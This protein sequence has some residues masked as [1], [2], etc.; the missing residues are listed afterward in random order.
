MGQALPFVGAGLGFLVGGPAGAQWGWAIGAAVASSQQVI[1]GP[2]IGEISRQTSQEGVPRPVVFALS[3]PMPGNIIATS[4]PRI[5]KK[6]QR[7]GKGGP[8]VETESVFRTYAIG[9]CEGPVAALVRVWRNGILVYDA[10]LGSTPDNVKFLQKARFFTGSFDQNPSPDLE[11]IFGVGTTPAHRGTAYVVVADDDLT[12]MRGAIPQYSFQITTVG[13]FECE[14]ITEYSNEV[15]YPWLAGEDPRNP[16]NLHVY[17]ERDDLGGGPCV[18]PQPSTHYPTLAEAYEVDNP[19]CGES[20]AQNVIGWDNVVGGGVDSFEGNPVRDQPFLALLATGIPVDSISISDQ[21]IPGSHAACEAVNLLADDNT[22]YKYRLNGTG[23]DTLSNGAYTKLTSGCGVNAWLPAGDYFECTLSFDL[24]TVSTQYA[25]VWR[26]PSAPT[27]P[28]ASAEPSPIPGYCII[29]GQAV[30]ST[31]WELVTGGIANN[32]RV[33]QKYGVDGDCL[34]EYPLNPALPTSDPNYS[35][36]SFWEAAYAEAVTDGKMPAGLTYGTDY[37][38]TQNWIYRRVYEVCPLSIGVE[39]LQNVVSD[40]CERAKLDA[41]KFNVENI[42]G[43]VRGFMLTNGYPA[44]AALQS[45]SEIYGF[46]PSNYD[47]KIHFVPRGWNSVA[48]ITESDMVDDDQ[49]I[50]QQKRSDSISIPRVLHLNYHD[51]NGGLNT[52]KQSSERAGDRRSVGE[53]SLQTAVILNAD[54]AARAVHINHK[55]LIEDQKGEL[56]FSLPDSFL[57]LSVAD[58]IIVQYQG[59]SERCRI[60][61]ND[62][63]DGYQEITAL[64]DRQSAY[65][66]SVEGIPAAPQTP[67]PSSLVGLTLIEPLDI[68]VLRDADDSIG[69]GYYV[70]ISGLLDAWQGATIELSLDGGANYI[71][72]ATWTVSAVMGETLTALSDHPQAYPDE[73]NSVAI[74][75]DTPDAELL[76]TDITGLLNRQN[77]AIIGNEMIQFANADETTS[78]EWEISHFLR[79]RKGTDTAQH[80]IGSRFVLLDRSAIPFI[81]A[82]LTELNRTLTF[83]AT[84]FGANPETGTVVSMAFEGISQKERAPSYIQAHIEGDDAVVSWQGVGRLGGGA[85]VAHGAYFIGYRVTITDGSLTQSVDTIS[86]SLTHDIS[87]FTGP[88]TISVQQRNQLTGVGPEIEVILANP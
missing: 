35:N 26:L 1:Q 78:G 7:Q 60:V 15:L 18:V 28:C 22:V 25:F 58:P 39:S 24:Q 33:L 52:D 88:L 50:E 64:R 23:D 80:A 10:R 8:K 32:T 62:I 68:H 2:K 81:P 82:D 6:R 41:D 37:P 43:D 31:E 46:D 45:L 56:K 73:V 53:N 44:F 87:A 74:R 16:S 76:E 85:Q 40:I 5:V 12:D 29:D 61:R 86:Q 79:G 57:S 65:T 11:A 75:L 3:P 69:L 47:G 51:V 20:Y 27:N 36:Q 30:E 4:E 83:R 13:S 67:P 71:D 72:S 77:L 34:V 14:T 59:R 63:Q 48:T 54:E 66:S 84:S 9:I 55:V 49:E 38:V 42:S 70:A 17:R 21:D 19:G